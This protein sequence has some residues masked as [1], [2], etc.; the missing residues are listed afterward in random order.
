MLGRYEQKA[1]VVAGM[2]EITYIHEP[3]IDILIQD[4]LTVYTLSAFIKN[5]SPNNNNNNSNNN[6]N[7]GSVYYIFKLVSIND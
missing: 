1:K 6:N 7:N 3:G 2:V 5:P 4:N